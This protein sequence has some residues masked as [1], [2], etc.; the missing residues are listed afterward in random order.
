MTR[1]SVIGDEAIT[2][3][4]RLLLQHGV[5]A[6]DPA[7]QVLSTRARDRNTVTTAAHLPSRSVQAEENEQPPAQI[8]SAAIKSPATK[9]VVS[10][11]TLQIK[12]E[13]VVPKRAHALQDRRVQ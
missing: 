12:G 2:A 3:V 4:R 5:Q 10:P 11:R 8:A 9:W 7:R 6:N 13:A 1:C